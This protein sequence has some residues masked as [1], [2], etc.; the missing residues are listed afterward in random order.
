VGAV[1]A[2]DLLGSTDKNSMVVGFLQGVPSGATT[3]FIKLSADKIV[4]ATVGTAPLTAGK[5]NVYI[6]YVV[7]D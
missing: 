7:G 6:E 2:T 1:S 3:S 5:F 4:K